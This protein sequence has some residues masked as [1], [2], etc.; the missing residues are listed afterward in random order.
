MSD[1]H[2]PSQDPLFALAE[3]LRA[4]RE[5][6]TGRPA[7]EAG[8]PPPYVEVPP[9]ADPVPEPIA[10]EMPQA[11][12]AESA[13]SQPEEDPFVVLA[14]GF[15]VPFVADLPEIPDFMDDTPAAQEAPPRVASDQPASPAEPNV[16]F[17]ETTAPI[18]IEGE[19]GIWEE[20]PDFAPIEAVAPVADGAPVE[21]PRFDVAVPQVED[22]AQIEASEAVEQTEETEET[23]QIEA[24][25]DDLLDGPVAAPAP[26]VA[27]VSGSHA[28]RSD[29]VERA[30]ADAAREVAWLARRVADGLELATSR[31]ASFDER[32]DQLEALIAH[33]QAD[34]AV[35]SARA[36]MLMP[37]DPSDMEE[38]SMALARLIRSD[39]HALREEFHRMSEEQ[40]IAIAE[41]QR[42]VE[43][44]AATARGSVDESLAR[45]DV[46]VLRL[47]DSIDARIGSAVASIEATAD[48]LR[49]EDQRSLMAA[50]DDR[51]EALARLVRSDNERLAAQL[52]AEIEIGKQVLRAAKELQASL[53]QD[54]ATALDQ[55]AIRA[56][57]T[58]AR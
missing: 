40:G 4:S 49:S 54:V 27:S 47:G 9:L 53:A 46:A 58:H 30:L 17:E 8:S 38:W 18:R 14:G 5:R 13:G 42:L 43:V 44:A 26:V 3:E 31:I 10:V 29:D 51:M 56:S 41:L 57:E 21:L 7:E 36:P 12:I 34:S 33:A 15:D 35:A 24:P 11:P 6:L 19:D 55:R 16:A 2:F 52:E 1:S 20:F 37:T 50:I 39:S 28:D 45:V 22:F 32:L 25:E 48:H 23:L